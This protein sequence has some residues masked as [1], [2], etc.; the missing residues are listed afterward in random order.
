V[1][2]EAALWR[3]ESPRPTHK[4]R[5]PVVRAD[6]GDASG[7]TKEEGGAALPEAKAAVAVDKRSRGRWFK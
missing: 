4:G 3:K 7:K 1:T 2:Q 6:D 5:R